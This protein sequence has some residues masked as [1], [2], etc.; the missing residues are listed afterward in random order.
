M[1]NKPLT[2]AEHAHLLGLQQA[3]DAATSERDA[4]VRFLAN[5]HGTNAQTWQLDLGSGAWVP[6]EKAKPG[7]MVEEP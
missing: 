6:V 5:Q 7:L 1:T 2:T 3:V 4:F